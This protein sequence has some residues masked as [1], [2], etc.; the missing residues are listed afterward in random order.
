MIYIY[1]NKRCGK[2]R[3]ALQEIE[4]TGQ[5]FKVIEYLNNP[6]SETELKHMLKLLDKKPL[7]LIRRKEEVFKLKFKG[8][9]LSDDA[10]IK[11]MVENPILIERPIVVAGD[12]AWV[13]RDEASLAEIRGLKG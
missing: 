13:A 10:W 8:Q 9:E 6:P 2:S 12:K 5:P 4:T 11:V 3:C 1:H 7:D